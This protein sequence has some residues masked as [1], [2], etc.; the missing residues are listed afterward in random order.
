MRKVFIGVGITAL[1]LGAVR[2]VCGPMYRMHDGC[3]CSRERTW[4]AFEECRVLRQTHL[5]L[6]TTAAGDPQHQHTYWDAQWSA[7]Y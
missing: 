1:L 7:Q 6:T 5:F 3:S 2:V 4:F